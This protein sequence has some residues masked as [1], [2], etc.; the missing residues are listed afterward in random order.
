MIYLLY[1]ADSYRS[2]EKLREIINGYRQKYG[3]FLN[4]S[5][6]DAEDQNL[7]DLK[8]AGKTQSLFSPKQM[9]VMENIFSLSDGNFDFILETAEFFKNRDDILV[10]WDGSELPPGK[11]VKKILE[12]SDKSQEFKTVDRAGI[13]LWL[14]KESQKRAIKLADYKESL[15]ACC[16]DNLWCLKNELDK[17][18]VGGF[19]VTN[20]RREE[21]VFNLSDNFLKNKKEAMR[22]LI[23]L[24]KLG[25]DESRLFSFIAGHFRNLLKVGSAMKLR[26]SLNAVTADLKLHPYVIKKAAAEAVRHDENF[27]KNLFYQVFKEDLAIKTGETTPQASLIR[28]LF[29]RTE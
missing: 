4:F 12:I 14:T 29:F 26:K 7:T 8:I 18:E 6:F 13:N 5:R 17:I 20:R 15:F 28:L 23:N 11:L 16:G 3:N 2:R 10:F 9:I 25:E 24:L 19:E 1:G 21:T 27:L 22:C